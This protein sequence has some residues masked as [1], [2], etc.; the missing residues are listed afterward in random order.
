MYSFTQTPEMKNVDK[1]FGN[2]VRRRGVL[3]RKAVNQGGL[4]QVYTRVSL[5]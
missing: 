5:G 2:A 4:Y 3:P 1:L